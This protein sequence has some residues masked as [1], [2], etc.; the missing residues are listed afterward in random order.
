LAI[1]RERKEKLVAEYIEMLQQAKG[2]I[3]AE[4]RGMTIKDVDELRARLREKN[5]GFAVTKN[6]LLKI[7]LK[8]VGMAAP[9]DLLVGPVALAVA[10][11]DLAA[12]VKTVLEYAGSSELFIAKG[13]V[14]G[15]TAVRGKDLKTISELPPIDVL[16]AQLLGTV[17]MPLAQFVGLLNEPSRQLVAVIKAG[18]DGLVNVLAAYSQKEAA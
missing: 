16:R 4:Y 12:T 15:S 2:V 18:S 11:D 13:G 6:T 14:I 8:E 1:S 10:Y 5:A 7:A 9:D 3:I 17:S